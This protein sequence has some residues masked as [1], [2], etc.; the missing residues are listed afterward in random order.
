L[1]RSFSHS[2]LAAGESPTKQE[3]FW[4]TWRDLADAA[5]VGSLV[6]D[7]HL[8]ALVREN[9]VRTIWT[10]DRGFRRFDGLDARDPVA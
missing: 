7:T 6:P 1:R 8:V 2:A 10:N 3:R 4:S 9:G 5:A